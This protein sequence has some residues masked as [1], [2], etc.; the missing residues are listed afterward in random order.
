MH[1]SNLSIE[2]PDVAEALGRLVHPDHRRP[3]VRFTAEM[4]GTAFMAAYP[5]SDEHGWCACN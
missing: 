3:V 4:L 1:L 5:W 2:P